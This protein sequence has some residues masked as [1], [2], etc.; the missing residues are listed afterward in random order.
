MFFCAIFGKVF[1]T[2]QVSD[3]LI[4][5]QDTL[6]LY[7]SPLELVPDITQKLQANEEDLEISSDCWRGFYAKWKI[8]DS[9]LY[10]TNIYE[11][12]SGRDLSSKLEKIL[13]RKFTNG[14][15]KADW[16]IGDFWCGKGFVPEQTLYIS[17]F[18]HECNFEFENGYLK[19][20]KQIDYLPCEYSDKE[21][22]TE[23]VIQHLDLNELPDLDNFSIGLSA[24]LQSDKIGKLIRVKIESSTDSRY[25]DAIKNAL[26]ELP[27]I[28]VYFY[29]GRFWDVGETVYLTI[30][31]GDIKKYVR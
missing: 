3:I 5:N 4:W 20:T 11:C 9:I 31:G 16:V 15:L 14:L 27:C 13:N 29:R 18:K 25:N 22:L 19:S 28:P 2:N 26:I 21:K 10:L 7:D 17:I 8:I 1:S 24:Y 30:N 23:F 12:N 6:F